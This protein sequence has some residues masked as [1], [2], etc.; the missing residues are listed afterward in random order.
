MKNLIGI[1]T[2][3][4]LLQNVLFSNGE[5]QPLL[6]YLSENFEAVIVENF[7]DINFEKTICWAYYDNAINKTGQV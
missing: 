5:I 4:L 7:D 2:L 1:L 3:F 6:Y